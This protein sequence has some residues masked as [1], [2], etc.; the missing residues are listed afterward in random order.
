MSV[1]LIIPSFDS[2]SFLDELFKSIESQN[3]TKDLEVMIGIDNC[4]KTTEYVFSKTFPL[5]FTFY[6]FEKNY[7]PYVIKNTLANFAKHENIV[8]FDSDDVMMEDFIKV[9]V[10]KL[11]MFE[12]VK[13]KYLNFNDDNGERTFV[14][15]KSQFGEGVFGIKKELF[16]N[17]NGFEGWKVAADSDFMGRLYSI[18]TK[19]HLTNKVLFHRRLHSQSLTIRPDTGY[20]SQLRARYY[21][22][23]KQK[24][25]KPINDELVTGIYKKI[26][27]IEKTMTDPVGSDHNDDIMEQH[28]KKLQKQ[29][30]LESIF[31]NKQKEIKPKSETK[32]INYTKINS[33]QSNYSQGSKI[34]ALKKAKLENLK[35]NFGRR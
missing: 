26:D 12:C 24:N 31:N 5:N 30:M 20:V 33:N 17:L 23:S 9:I 32:Q 1:S 7:G 22:L 8:F 4:E 18:G 21:K 14:E 15:E 25:N 35:K 16:L 11:N 34:S 13:P 6:F 2:I 10:D 19:V 28:E 27:L 3:F 29:K